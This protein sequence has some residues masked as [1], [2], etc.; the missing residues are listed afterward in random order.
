MPHRI[1]IVEDEPLVLEAY[2]AKLCHD[3]AFELVTAETLDDAIRAVEEHGPF[4]AIVVDGCFPHHAGADPFPE[5]GRACNGEK[6]VRWLRRRAG[7]E[8]PILACSSSSEFNDKMVA[9]GA[10]RAVVKGYGVCDAFAELFPP[11]SAD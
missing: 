8:G 5:R 4:E 2:R 10:T 1:L 7:Y 11:A 6:L 9:G 3:G